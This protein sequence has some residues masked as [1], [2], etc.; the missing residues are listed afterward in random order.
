MIIWELP[1]IH[2]Y[3]IEQAQQDGATVPIY[4]ESRLARLELKETEMP[5]IDEEVE[6]LTENEEESVQAKIKRRWATLEK[7]AGARPRLERIAKDLLEHFDNRLAAMPG[8]GMIVCMSRNICVRLYNEI[9]KLRPEQH[10]PKLLRPHL[11]SKKVKKDLEKRFKD[12]G[13]PLLLVIVRDMWLTGFDVPCLHTM[14]VDKPMKGHNLMQAIARVNRVF[15]EKPGGLVA[16]Y[17]GIA[18][19]LRHAVKDYT[20]SKGRGRPAAD[21]GEAF[22]VMWEKLE[23]ARGLLHGFDYSA[24]RER[25]ML[26]LPGAAEHVLAQKDGKKRFADTVLALSKAFALCSGLEE[27]LKYRDEIA[28]LQA[29][30][31]II[32]KSGGGK[33]KIDW[34]KR[35]NTLRQIVSRAVVSDEVIDIFSAAGL[36]RPDIGLLSDEFLEEV[37]HLE[38]KNLAVELLERLLKDEIQSRFSANVVQNK[39]FSELLKQSLQRYQNR[40]VE[41]AQVI[42][43][44]IQ[45]AKEFADAARRGEKLGL[46]EE[47][48]AFYDALG[49]NESSVRE[50]GEPVLKKI[51]R[52]L[53]G[54]LRKNVRVDWNVRESVRASL[55]ILVRRILRKYKYPP[56]KQ[57][58]AIETVLQQA[59]RISEAWVNDNAKIFS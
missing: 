53:T 16:D 1:Y 9:I 22:V 31:A 11:Y 29:I 58:T 30:K 15:K 17:I 28:F 32:S 8:K 23:I 34:E 19:E 59:E 41:T 4:Y 57:K 48:L 20:N 56:D 51:A 33:E 43:E 14:Y 55:R 46:N 49:T 35:E 54:N 2:I 12:P 6:E 26:L 42:E 39:K 13:D 36:Q 5:V 40:S 27:A 18:N 7:L 10:D 37:S 25:A 38:H 52:E 24:Y 21:T 3:D 44:L 50:L 45:M 47:E